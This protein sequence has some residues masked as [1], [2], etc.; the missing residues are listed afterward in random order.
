MG[1]PVARDIVE[2]D[3]AVGVEDGRDHTDWSLKSVHARGNPAEVMEA[4]D[5]SDGSVTAH[6]QE[7]HIVEEEDAAEGVLLGRWYQE[8]ADEDI[9][10]TGFIDDGRAVLVEVLPELGKPLGAGSRTERRS[11]GKDQTG[12]FA[13]G[14]GINDLNRSTGGWRRRHRRKLC[15][16][17]VAPNDG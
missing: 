3:P 13:A 12:R 4:S 2:G 9:G 14:V 15:Q 1:F 5:D 11:P 6:S 16:I 17:R 10:A 7:P 8:G